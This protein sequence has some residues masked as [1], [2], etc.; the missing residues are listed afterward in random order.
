MQTYTNYSLLEG[1]LITYLVALKCGVVLVCYVEY[2]NSRH[3]V[4][5]ER[6]KLSMARLGK[7][8]Y[9]YLKLNKWFKINILNTC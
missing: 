2:H 5:A 8:L 1:F 9:K 7:M 3:R 6:M 4:L